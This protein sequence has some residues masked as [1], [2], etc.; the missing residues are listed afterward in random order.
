MSAPQRRGIPA[1]RHA[2]EKLRHLLALARA[3]PARSTIAHRLHACYTWC[4]DHPYLPELV[5]LAETVASWWN[6]IEAFRLTGITNAKSEG[7]NF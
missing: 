7:N 6:E 5:T 4:A 1:G 2:E 3:S